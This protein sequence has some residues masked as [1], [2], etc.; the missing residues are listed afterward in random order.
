MEFFSDFFF[1]IVFAASYVFRNDGGIPIPIQEPC[2]ANKICWK[3]FPI[4]DFLI[5][6]GTPETLTNIFIK[7]FS[8]WGSFYSIFHILT[9]IKPQRKLFHPFK[10]NPN[11]PPLS[12]VTKEILRSMRGVL[13]CSIYEFLINDQHVRE[14]LP[15][16]Q[17]PD[18]LQLTRSS[19]NHELLQLNGVGL[20]VLLLFAFAWG[21]FHFYWT[22]RMLHTKWLYKNVHKVH[23]ES[24]N[25]DP[26]SGT[27]ILFQIQN[28]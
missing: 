2:E 25:P 24:Y 17:L 19:E 14:N 4:W 6:D 15:L 1:L 10:F 22:H 21:D 12:L 26:F 9:H 18:I 3:R 11:Y 20:L 23:H 27:P 13:I 7:N 5:G 16:V 8:L 28:L